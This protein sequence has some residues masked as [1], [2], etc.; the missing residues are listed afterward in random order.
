MIERP[1]DCDLTEE[2]LRAVATTVA[3]RPELWEGLVH[4]DPTQ[5]TYA[6]LLHDDRLAIW[7]IYWLD[8]H[9]TGF[10]DHDGSSGALAVA[11]GALLEERLRLGDPPA[12]RVAGPGEVVSFSQ[13]DIHRVTS[14]G[15]V[16]TVSLHAYSPPLGG[17]G[18][19]VVGP[20][21]S[22]GRRPLSYEED[23]RPLVTASPTP[24][25]PG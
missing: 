17:M 15:E 18:S 7:L 10:H 22:L 13:W 16:P 14:A 24:R 21:G 6:E 25:D 19:Y 20:E 23:L 5:R 2:E 9:D 1:V 11:R 8:G 12:S 4:H 3:Q